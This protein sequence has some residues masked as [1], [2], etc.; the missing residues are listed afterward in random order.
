MDPMGTN[1]KTL[2]DGLFNGERSSS[3]LNSVM[4]G[5][6]APK[7]PP[8]RNKVFIAGL[9]KGNQ[10]LRSPDHKALFLGGYVGGG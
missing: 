10:W 7:V 9:I 3:I 5:Q 2:V 8:R 4:A 6:P 1:S